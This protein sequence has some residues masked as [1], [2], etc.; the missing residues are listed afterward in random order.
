M[1]IPIHRP[2]ARCLLPVMFVMLAACA[3]TSPPPS[4]T[5]KKVAGEATVLAVDLHRDHGWAAIRKENYQQA[6]RYF[7]QVL[8]ERKEDAEAILGLGEAYLGLNR[9]DD[10]RTQFTRIGDQAPPL[11]RARALQGLG[12]A[13]LR[14]GDSEQAKTLLDQAIQLDPTLWRAWNGLGRVRDGEQDHVAAR[15]A[16]RKAIKLKPRMAFLHNNLGF[17]LLASGE[18][19]YAESALNKALELDPE[20]E[21]ASANLRLALALQ[22]R[23]QAA[24]AGVDPD[25]KARVLNNVGYGALLRGDLQKAR[26]LF[27]DAMQAEPSFFREARRNLAYLESIEAEQDLAD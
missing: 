22:G 4:P 14:Q 5:G 1:T 24:L 7:S 17:S 16:F 11:R 21:V 3:D 25:D 23:Y 6:Q 12:I 18:P 20:L 2:R 26:S 9:L 19:A 15:Y 13:W 8:K 10:A 27:L